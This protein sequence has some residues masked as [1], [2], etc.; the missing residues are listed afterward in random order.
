MALTEDSDL[1]LAR[2]TSITLTSGLVIGVRP[3]VPA[4]REGI[5]EALPRVSDRSLF[6]R[7]F[8]VV[9]SLSDRE[10]DYLTAVDYH[11]HFAWV[12]YT[13]DPRVG[14]GVARY[15]RILDEP[16][17]AEAAITVVDSHQQ[18]GISRILLELLSESAQANGI[19]MFRGY[20]LPK[21][22]PVLDSA[23]RRGL[24]S[25]TESGIAR[26]DVE[27]PPPTGLHSSNIYSL[28]KEVAAGEIEF[29]T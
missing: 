4:D 27:L 19:R 9:T 2:S 24:S 28:L 16:E 10:L 17:V 20:A 23:S 29:G 5:P 14:L 12:A 26:L 7:F 18:M 8:R 21:N 1:I 22:R 11:D 15:I 3:I 6:R 13:G 25:T